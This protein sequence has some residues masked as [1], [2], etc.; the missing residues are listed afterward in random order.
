MAKLI[1]CDDVVPGCFSIIEG[2]DE[3]EVALKARDHARIEHGLPY[4]T[5]GLTLLIQQAIRDQWAGGDKGMPRGGVPHAPPPQPPHGARG[6]GL[7]AVLVSGSQA[8]VGTFRS[9]FSDVPEVLV[10]P[11][12]EAGQF[13]PDLPAA[14]Q[15]V[16][17]TDCARLAV[18]PSL[19]DRWRRALAPAPVAVLLMARRAQLDDALRLANGR[20]IHDVIEVPYHP[21]YLRHKIQTVFQYLAE[22]QGTR[23]LRE[24]L[25]EQAADFREFRRV[26]LALAAE[27]DLNH[28]LELIV[29]KC[30]EITCAD[31]GSLYLVEEQPGEPAEPTAVERRLRFVVAQN[32]SKTLD[33]A[34]THLPL[35]RTSIAG[36]VALTRT[37]L[38]LPD[39]YHLPRH[40]EF[41]F[42]RQ[43]DASFAYRT[44]SMLVVPLI[45]LTNEVIGVLQII[46]RKRAP[47]IRLSTPAVAIAEALPF[48]ARDLGQVTSLAN[49]AAVVTVKGRR[50]EETR[51]DLEAQLRHAQKI[52]AVGRLAGGVA[53]DFNNMLTVIMNRSQL[54]LQRV[55]PDDALRRHIALIETTTQRAAGLTR[56]LLALSRKQE[57]QPAVLDLNAL[58]ASMQPMLERL[59]G[60]DVPLHIIQHPGLDRTKADS[61]QLEQVIMNLV[62][63]ARDA[64]PAGGQLTLE[65][66]N[67]DLDAT[68]GR[69]HPG[70]KPG[71]YVMLAVTDTGVGMD[72]AVQAHLF[73]PF[74]TTK[75][76]GKGTGLG[77]ATVYSI[78]KQHQG[79]I[80]V[81]STPGRGSIFRVYLPRVDEP[82]PALE[83]TPVSAPLA[84]GSETILLIEDEEGVRVVVREIL[85][86]A[87]YTV[88]EAR[89]GPEALLLSERH[90]GMIDLVLTDIVMP[91]MS[92]PQVAGRLKVTR[93][94]LKVLYM[95]GY[96]DETILHH[97][98]LQH[99]IDVLR[100]PFTPEA[101]ARTV[102]AVLS[103]TMGS[104]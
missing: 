38:N 90:R 55:A 96:T 5:A 2:K 67:V 39:V 91:L 58:T 13:P 59:I 73:E 18:D 35:N 48:G 102:R 92:G 25:I 72:A 69:V 63:N 57:L 87:G 12:T 104:E 23:G 29:T 31:A 6:R 22:Q 94:G 100:K 45:G 60:E 77:L 66:A 1:R 7:R 53:H 14:D 43:M 62:V 9:M 26:A 82:L 44:V 36:Y 47:T 11:L 68:F 37:P 70:A 27:A 3:V 79:Y 83:P 93:P 4:I 85:Q 61:G 19:V 101:L 64:M 65:T 8:E 81:E 88:L 54:L 30:R 49:L 95:S 75:G 71:R 51:R 74:F 76:P 17:L 32:D 28:L 15:A 16:I 41:S 34:S 56:Q 50:A 84:R 42:N 97:G 78:V 52:D 89:H 80:S 40:T 10:T 103:V 86:A 21:G 46:N 98:P 24:E 33:L 99:S 20:E